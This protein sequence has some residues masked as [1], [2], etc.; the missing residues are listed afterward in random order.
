VSACR[1]PWRVQFATAAGL[2]NEMVEA[3]QQ[4][5][6]SR[7]V[8]RWTRYEL[9]AID[10]V[11]YVPPAEVGAELLSQVISEPAERA[12]VILTRLFDEE[13]ALVWRVQKDLWADNLRLL[14]LMLRPALLLTPPMLLLVSQLDASFGRTPL[15][16]GRMR[17]GG[18][19]GQL[20]HPSVAPDFGAVACGAAR[21][22]DCRA[23]NRSRTRI[24]LP[25]GWLAAVVAGPRR[26]THR[27]GLPGGQAS[28]ARVVCA[29]IHGG[30]VGVP[31]PVP[32]RVIATSGSAR[33]RR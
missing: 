33:P 22:T 26:G 25:S 31:A 23:K 24:A 1:Q 29:D 18:A 7:A 15:P 4:G 14:R 5:Q 16:A 17:S 8:G 21:G 10:D 12:A 20:A 32:G 6:L 19:P 11:G 30:R 9:I 2:V 27:S 13:T 3:W 28:L